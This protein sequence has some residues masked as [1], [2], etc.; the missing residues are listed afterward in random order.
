MKILKE[1]RFPLGEIIKVKNYCLSRCFLRDYNEAEAIGFTKTDVDDLVKR[2]NKGKETIRRDGWDVTS[3]FVIGKVKNVDGWVI[4]DGQG[5]KI[6]AIDLI[7]EGV[8]HPELMV[9]A[10]YVEYETFE[11]MEKHIASL[12][13][14]AVKTPYRSDELFRI[15]QLSGGDKSAVQAYEIVKTKAEEWGSPTAGIVATLIF[16]YDAV[17]RSK[18]RVFKIEEIDNDKLKLYDVLFTGLNALLTK[19]G[20]SNESIAKAKNFSSS[21]AY[22]QILNNLRAINPELQK[23]FVA[24]LLKIIPKLHLGDYKDLFS[25]ARNTRRDKILILSMKGLKNGTELLEALQSIYG[26]FAA[27]KRR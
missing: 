1:G 9:F 5:R 14:N 23:V 18:D 2:I 15:K 25:G 12:N 11:E 16:D 10:F 4:V 20:Y 21:E 8:L 3:T 13:S 24:R 6:I 22:M 19:K 7:E 26:K 17:R 27:R